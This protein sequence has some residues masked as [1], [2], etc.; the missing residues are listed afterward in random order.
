MITKA[1]RVLPGDE[2][3]VLDQVG[4]AC[5]GEHL[6]EPAGAKQQGE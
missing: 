4:D 5:D 1:M 3:E 6:V 2:R